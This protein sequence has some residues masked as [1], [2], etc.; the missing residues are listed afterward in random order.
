M[1][2]L[3]VGSLL[4]LGLLLAASAFGQDA[5]LGGT[6]ADPS[7]GVIPGATVTATNDSTGVVST[8]V[9]NSAG[10]YSFSR[11]LFGAYT[12]KAEQKGF[13]SKSITKVTLE[14]GQQARLNFQLQVSAM[15]TSIEVT[16]SGE[17]LIL[18]SS[19]SSGGVLTERVVEELPLVNRNALDLIKIMSGVV[20]ADDPIFG[21]ANTS[22]AGVAASA[23]NVQRDGITVNDVRFPTG[24]NSP[25]RI[26]PD[27]VGEFRMVLAPVDAEVGRGNAQVQ[28]ATK[29]GGNAYHGAAVWNVQNT[30]LDPNSWDNKRNTPV[31]PAAWRNL[32][33]YSINVGGPI[34]KN[35][36][37]FFALFDGQVAKRRAPYNA[38]TL[39]PCARRGIFRYFDRW[40][41]GN[42]RVS[43][44]IAAG[45]GTNPVIATVNAQGNPVTPPWEPGAWNVTP[46][47]GQLRYASVFGAITNLSTLAPDCSN[48][49]FSSTSWDP[50]RPGQDPSGFIADYLTKL[51][52]ANNY[53]IGD[54]LNLAGFRWTR[55]AEGSNNL[56][57]IGEDTYRKQ[58]NVRIDHNFSQKHR[59]NGSWSFE[60]NHADDTLKTWPTNSW[61]GGGANQPQV[62][63]VNFLSNITAT[64]L[65]EVKFGTSRTGS[66]IFTPASRPSNGN[67]LKEYLAQF[68]T[69]PNGEVGI[70]EP[71][72]SAGIMNN[73]RTDGGVFMAPELNIST[74]YGTRGAWAIG[75]LID[76]SPRYSFGDTVSWV[77]GTHSLRMG[78]EFRR[79]SSES[80]GQW[81]F[82]PSNYQWGDSFPEIMGGELPLTPQ[83]FTNAP[84]LAGSDPNSGNKRLMRDL[85]IFQS[86]SLGQIKQVRY[87]N[88]IDATTWNDPV[89]EPHMVRKT[90]MK[91][92][93]VFV[94]DDWKIRPDLTLNLGVRWDYYGV[95][96]LANGMTVGLVGGGGSIFG[97]SGG[98]DNWFTPI[99][100]GDTA[101]GDLVSPRSIGPGS[102]HPDERL[103]PKTWTNVGPAIG[104]AYELPWF[105]K[106]KTTIRGGFQRSYISMAGNFQSV[107]AAAGSSP[108]FFN[109]N[110]WNNGGAWAANDYFG[111]KD[112]AANPIFANGV[113]LP[114][115]VLPGLVEFPLYDRQQS[116]S[117]Y[118]PDYGYPMV[119]NLT[120]AVTRN[121]TSNLV[122]DLRY[123]GT[124]TRRNFSS[125]DLN[126][127]NFLTN[128]LLQAFDAARAGQDPALLDQL[129]NGVNLNP[130]GGGCTIDGSECRGGAALR[131]ASFP[132][133]NTFSGAG[134]FTPLNSLLANGN[135]QGLANMLN[136]ENR[137]YGDP[138]GKYM[139]DNGFPVNF[140]KAS[141][142]FNN[143]TFYE[144]LGYDNYH[145]FQ[146]QVTLRPTHGLSFQ[147][148][149]TLSKNLG[150]SGGLSPD[151]RDL[152]TG[153]TLQGSDRTHN[154][155]TFGTFDLPFGKSSH[156]VLARAISG[157][158]MGWITN[159]TSG[160][161]L[162]LTANCG[163]Y[164][165]CAPD[166]AN[167]G[168]DPKSAGLTWINDH[169][170]LFADRYVF[171]GS[172]P[173]LPLKDPQCTNSS[174]V[175]SS[176]QGLCTLQAVV[177]RTNGQIV[178]QNPLPGKM[179]NAGYNTF[180]N[181]TR[182]NA[183]MS[184]SKSVSVTETKSFRLRVDISNLFN[185]PISSSQPTAAGRVAVPTAPSMSINGGAPIGQYTYK[186]G[187]RTLQA[188]A[189]FD[190]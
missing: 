154:W 60:K 64:F 66:N 39:T 79:S 148:T 49:T 113:P 57:G 132:N 24:I 121:V 159:V 139:E 25:T 85:L 133:Y 45:G 181:Y 142:Q 27:M 13:Q 157:W 115:N 188:M 73:F 160:A 151:P 131:A 19:S 138:L 137:F 172:N 9:T 95:P 46:Y 105:G 3:I 88:S 152:S 90:I 92:F 124:L 97:P 42:A 80:K 153:Y 123:I 135:Y 100:Q 104:F 141:P 128:G 14:S 179:G 53:D 96:Y 94:K 69:L 8:A 171:T 122:V 7:G 144:N 47:T 99:S 117:A 21:A 82:N 98:Y 30:A 184:I 118:A 166:T 109:I 2:K 150:N 50:V 127:P 15:A 107:E 48:A 168:I 61:S 31:T 164:G 23:V 169:G 186:V 51:P 76:N 52:V 178:L 17:Q 165:N 33:E 43:E 180:R 108:G 175:A 32:Q 34:I 5:S 114:S 20:V 177:D 173:E 67:T 38:M 120:F 187:G 16:E 75:D 6:V 136:V 68:G 81:L 106:G 35:K 28:I 143:A 1:R 130:Y 72:P 158:Q 101:T 170:T 36:T 10:V 176:L 44:S 40:N 155:V 149:Y 110:T 91:E 145:S 26:N 65:N 41:N 140:I 74:P 54:G 102:Q 70:V 167:G 103:Y 83:D 161:P 59:I 56:W 63:S 119:N 58:I 125:K 71:G 55:T 11:L 162:A 111:I 77:K 163:L 189:R 174:I 22:F 62:L 37:F 147:S 134:A 182:W 126:A 183:D 12:V 89:K 116:V 112:I 4:L 29:A 84:G 78:G 190:F 87:I 93:S 156:G 86:G 18:E 129:L 146:A 185:H